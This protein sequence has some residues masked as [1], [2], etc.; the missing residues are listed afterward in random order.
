MAAS[1]LSW[2]CLLQSWKSFRGEFQVANPEKRLKY[3]VFM[4]ELLLEQ[5]L[6]SQKAFPKELFE[7]QRLVVCFVLSQHRQAVAVEGDIH[8]VSGVRSQALACVVV[9]D[10][11][12]A[13]TH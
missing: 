8:V 13:S 12:R 7:L 10:F 6:R 3:N 2:S 9:L 5:E 4:Q 11:L 1:A